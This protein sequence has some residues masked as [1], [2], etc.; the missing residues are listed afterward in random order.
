M[1]AKAQ[2]SPIVSTERKKVESGWQKTASG[3]D[4]WMN[5][6]SKL[7]GVF[8]EIGISDEQSREITWSG[9]CIEGRTSGVGIL[10]VNERKL[11]QHYEGTMEGG[12]MEGQGTLS[13]NNETFVGNFK[14]SEFISGRVNTTLK[15]GTRYDGE[16]NNAGPEGHGI[17]TWTSGAVY[18]GDWRKGKQT[19][20]G[21]L[22][23]NDKGQYTYAGQF[24]DGKRDGQGVLTSQRGD[25]YE[26]EWK[27]NKLNG[28]GSFS[29]AT[30]IKYQG[31]FADDKMNGFGVMTTPKGSRYEGNWVNGTVDGEGTLVRAGQEQ[32]SGK[33]SHGCFNEG[34]RHTSFEVD[35]STC[36]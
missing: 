28:L 5:V 35:S 2:S 21:T 20:S 14:Q 16:W 22:K 17:M 12:K 8:P 29:S 9:S 7:T 15:D 10:D 19:G 23:Y 18:D 13:L 6:N 34:P 3:C 32:F 11:H 24:L 26:G 33:W 31:G 30:G 1:I 25:R 36:P 27:D 4:V